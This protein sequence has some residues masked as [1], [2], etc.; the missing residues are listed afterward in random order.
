MRSGV[1]RPT[2]VEAVVGKHVFVENFAGCLGA[3]AEITPDNEHL[4]RTAF[5]GRVER[6]S[7]ERCSCLGAR[8][9]LLIPRRAPRGAR[10]STRAE[11]Q[12]SCLVQS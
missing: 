11:W 1:D 8:R 2:R 3:V 6:T 12:P 5:L 4:L 10:A 7:V 9:E